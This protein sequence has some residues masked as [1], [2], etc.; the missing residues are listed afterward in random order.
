MYL[1]FRRVLS[2]SLA[3]VLAGGFLA[4]ASPP[5]GLELTELLGKPAAEES[6]ADKF[7]ARV[8][9]TADKIR[10]G[11][12][13]TL[14]VRV[15]LPKDFYIYST[16]SEFAATRLT[17]ESSPGLEAI[18]DTFQSDR[19][20]KSEF[21]PIVEKNVEKFYNHVNWTRRYRILANAVPAE[22]TVVGQLAG[23]YCSTGENG[24]CIP[25][26]PAITFRPELTLAAATTSSNATTAKPTSPIESAPA[27]A[28]PTRPSPYEVTTVPER[29]SAD[30]KRPDPLELRFAL[31]P[32]DARAGE[33]VTL[34]VE[35]ALEDGWHTFAFD[36][37]PSMAGLPTEIILT[38][39]VGMSPADDAF[40]TDSEI[41]IEKPLENIVQRV[42]YGTVVWT[43]QFRVL[44]DTPA[45]G[46]GVS[47]EIRYQIC[48]NRCLPLKDVAFELGD[49]SGP[50]VAI[51]PVSSGSRDAAVAAGAEAGNAPNLVGHGP[52]DQPFETEDLTAANST[53]LATYLLYAFLGGLILNVMPCV[54]PVIA[55][56]IMS[57]VQQAGE[58]RGRVLALN[59]AYSAGVI[60]V[61]VLLAT[62]AVT[63]KLGWGGLFQK[64][65][66]NLVMAC[67]VFAMGLSLLGV[68]EIPVPGMVG[69]AAGTV[70]R[71]GLLGAFL[72]G[73][74]ATL[75][76]TPCSGPFMGT[77]LTWSVR[78][79]S[80]ITFLI[81]ATMGVGMASP[82]IIFGLIP[83][84]VRL[85]PRPG[86]WMVRFKEISG[87]VLMGAVIFIVNSIASDFV[88][89][90][91]VMLLG[92]AFGLWM[93]G[94]LY[95]HS[96]HIR[97][98]MA[99]RLT[100]LAV[101]GGMCVDGS[102]LTRPS[103]TGLPCG[104]FATT[105][106]HSALAEEKTVL[107]DFTADWCLVCKT[108]ETVALNTRETLE[109][110]RQHD[111]IPMYADYTL[112]SEEI[113][114]WLNRFDSISVPLTV[115][116]PAGNP[117][118]PIIIRDAYTKTM[119][120][121]GLRKAVDTGK[122][123]QSTSSLIVPTAASATI[124]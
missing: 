106:L 81:W 76:A 59:L 78:Q 20:P 79:P 51:S 124:H 80:H 72:T 28:V 122:T 83:G 10:A 55:I 86:M 96:T 94:N 27:P 112:E 118:Q 6:G 100:A 1:N 58:S 45:G 12:I 109:L 18:D 88:I 34:Q 66:F 14:S 50:A 101:T 57:F 121:D 23:Q 2:V 119:L 38:Q 41:H 36:Q 114:E 48:K 105:T 120:L 103:A 52:T 67:L 77:T 32:A 44:P 71:E 22:T 117:R 16:T 62:L 85:L 15:E 89:P 60:G 110:V 93:V 90:L 104:D 74:F 49:L 92:I 13:A 56:K 84:A 53:G 102:T 64:P 70:Q 108:N 54:L 24:R 91:L 111:I 46:Y 17:I 35:V 113:K 5:A 42:H 19:A 75:L 4:Q 21:E 43:R 3:I 29:G 115:I 8:E 95:D 11:G 39:L 37:D 47:G 82:Y 31:T 98:K 63:L 7:S 30:R 123:V 40:K 116:F 69:S 61:F 107:V 65:E 26:R 99:V 87:F 97:H 9:L 68:F 73:I 33:L 25:I